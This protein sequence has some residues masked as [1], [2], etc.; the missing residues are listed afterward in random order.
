MRAELLGT[1]V[2]VHRDA[3][4]AG[5]APARA[6][7]RRTC[8]AA[9]C[10]VVV[11]GWDAALASVVGGLVGGARDRR[12][13]EH[14]LRRDL[15]RR[16]RA[17]GDDDLVR[18]GRRGREHRRRVRRGHDRGAD[19]A[20]R[21]AR[22]DARALH[23]LHRR[24]RGRHAARRADRRGRDVE[25]PASAST[26]CGIELGKAERHGI[27]ATTV[28]VVGAP[29]Q[30]HRHWSSI[31]AQIDAARPAR[32]RARRAR[33]APSRSS[34]SPR[35]AS[36]GSTPEQ[37][38]F[39]EVGAVD[40]IGEVVGVALALESLERRQGRS[41]R[42]CRSAAASS[43]PRTAGSRCPRPRR[44]RCSRARRSTASTSPLE[45]VTP[46]RRGARRL[47]RRRRFGPIPRMTLEGSGYGAGTR[48]LE[49][50]PNVVR[51]MLGSRGRR[52]AA[53]R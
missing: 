9:D 12:A 11:A 26:A 5:P 45:L 30:P 1:T 15:R 14:R 33:S 50:C 40:A 37:V 17:A 38:H 2:L 39:H 20:R 42:R 23:R 24:R 34:R 52:P 43:R 7:A 46:D 6:R 47:A 48:D 10:V 32:A 22:R 31:R 36:T 27:M 13:H 21:R 49:R 29:G 53:S 3:G 16:Q 51:A 44:S 4:V 19:R 8:G 35:A 28:T 41:A 25:L 18:R